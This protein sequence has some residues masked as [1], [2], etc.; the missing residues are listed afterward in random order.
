MKKM[1]TLELAREL[2]GIGTIKSIQNRLNANRAGAIYLIYRLRK[3]G[4]VKTLYQR[5]KTRVYKISPEYALGG[6][7]YIE[8]INKYSPIKLARFD[9]HQIYGRKV[10]IEETLIYAITKREV[11]YIIA[12]LSLFRKIKDW[13]FLYQMAKKEGIVREVAALYDISRLFVAKVRRM[14]KRI[15]NLATPNK[16]EKY[17]YIID[18]FDSRD[19]KDIENKWKVYIPLN[20]SDLREYKEVYLS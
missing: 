19:F 2:E 17:K 3:L 13:G 10:S 4:F 14:P 20:Y 12:C 5:N 9:I 8:I 15:R 1:N 11:R 16:N 18:G 6:T 7:D